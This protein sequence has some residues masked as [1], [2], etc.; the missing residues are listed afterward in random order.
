MGLRYVPNYH[1]NAGHVGHSVVD[2]T[3]HPEEV[4]RTVGHN[5]RIAADLVAGS[6]SRPSGVVQM[7][8]H[9][10][11]TVV[12]DTVEAGSRTGS[13]GGSCHTLAGG[14]VVNSNLLVVEDPEEGSTDSAAGSAGGR[15]CPDS[16]TCRWL[17]NACVRR[18]NWN[19]QI[20]TIV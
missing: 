13:E 11:H 16:T 17:R 19:N 3:H 1:W 5:F 10:F 7:V 12:E 14:Q 20:E 18:Q 8:G 9:N 6:C 4:V 15:G 2:K